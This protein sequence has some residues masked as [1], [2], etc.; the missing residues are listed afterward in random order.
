MRTVVFYI[1]GHGFG[2]ASRA[3]EVINALLARAADVR[4]IARTTAPQWLFDRTVRGNRF[5]R[6]DGI[7]DTGVSQIDSLRLDERETIRRARDFMEGFDAR[8]HA[9]AEW[10]RA[11]AAALVVADIPPLGIE[12]AKCAGA[13]AVALGNFTWD[14]IYSGYDGTKDVVQQIGEAYAAADAALR[15]PMHGGFETVPRVIDIPFIARRAT[16]DPRE[17]RQTLGFPLDTR[18]VL[19][20]FG[21]YGLEGLD[22]DALD[23]LNGYAVI[24]SRRL[25]LDE[26][27]MYEAGIRY[28][29]VVRAVDVV[30]T[31]PGYGIVSECIA[32]RT[33]VLYT[34]RGRFVEYDVLVREMPR[35]LR[36]RYIDHADLF[37]GRW[38]AHLEALLAQPAPA[39]EP[40]VNGADVAAGL[41]LDM[42][43]P[44]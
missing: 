8:V 13:P 17:V 19:V 14:W 23:D 24:G 35:F 30:A 20:S 16:R 3:I 29:D 41:L 36:V 27:A 40:P 12:A 11:H 21:G 7:T 28:E 2:H 37:A 43:E 4:V 22:A 33:A 10:L 1:S 34:S 32:N 9:E 42:M 44:R 38:T 6:V 31:K 25:Q 18:L 39:E 26:P 15:L 5:Q